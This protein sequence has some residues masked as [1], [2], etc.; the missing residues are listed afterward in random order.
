[1][2]CVHIQHLELSQTWLYFFPV[3]ASV[4]SKSAAMNIG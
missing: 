3:R 1:L 4:S 2:K